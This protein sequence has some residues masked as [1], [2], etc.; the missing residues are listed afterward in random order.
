MSIIISWTDLTDFNLT[1]RDVV[2]YYA[3]DWLNYTSLAWVQ[4]NTAITAKTFTFTHT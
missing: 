3:L 1:G 2:T 4:V